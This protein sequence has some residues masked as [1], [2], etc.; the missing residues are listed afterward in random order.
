MTAHLFVLGPGYTALPIIEKAR[1]SGWNVT[2]TVRSEKTDEKIARPYSHISFEAGRLSED[3]DVTHILCTI[4]PS[5]SGDPSLEHWSKWIRD[6]KNLQSCHYLSST[7]VYGD[8]GGAW[9]D[10]NTKPAPSLDRGHYRLKAEQAWQATADAA[11]CPLFIYRL[12]GIYGPGR[13]ALKT[14]LSGKA[15]RIIKKGQQFGRIHVDDIKTVIWAAMCSAHNGGFFSVTDDLP[16]PPQTVIEAAARLL[17]V[18]PPRKEAFETAKM[19]P[20]A[21]SFYAEN[22]RV[23]NQKIKAELGAVLQYPTYEEGLAALLKDIES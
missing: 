4:A 16:T 2:V 3:A 9:V 7:N 12:A 1:K 23:R 21:R 6:Q 18:S 22:K 20:M 13:N 17:G 10:E 8:H 14:I 11:G 5:A 15:R 19:S